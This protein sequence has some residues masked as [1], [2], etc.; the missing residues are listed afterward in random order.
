MVRDATDG[1]GAE[2]VFDPVGGDTFRSSQRCVASEG[3]IVLIGFAGGEIQDMPANRVLFRNHDILGLYMGA[4]SSGARRQALDSVHEE[5]MGLLGS[6]QLTPLVSAR[7]GLEDV[8]ATLEQ[9][10]DRRVV[11]RSVACPNG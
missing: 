6:G 1:Q 11:G 5:L 9:L 8:A 2:V 3:R 4:Y 10:R 7:V